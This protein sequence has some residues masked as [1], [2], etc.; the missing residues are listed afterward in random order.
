MQPESPDAKRPIQSAFSQCPLFDGSMG[1]EGGEGT[2]TNRINIRFNSRRIRLIDPDNLTPKFLLDGLR[3]AGLIHDDTP[4]EI[5]V[6]TTQEKVS[7]KAE[8]ETIIEITYID[9]QQ[10]RNL[11]DRSVEKKMLVLQQERDGGG[12]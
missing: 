5:T 1:E 4:E 9:E 6:E 3:Y 7:T 2:S 8:E 10:V 12:V 11:L